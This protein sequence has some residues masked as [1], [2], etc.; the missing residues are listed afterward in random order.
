[1]TDVTEVFISTSPVITLFAV[2]Y[3]LRRLRFFD[4]G[5][6]DEL[7]KLVLYVALPALLFTVFRNLPLSGE[8]LTYFVIVFVA[9]GVLLGLG[10]FLTRFVGLRS[11]YAPFMFTGFETGMLGYAVFIAAFGADQASR[12][13]SFDLGQLF[14]VWI[15]LIGPLLRLKTGTRKPGEITVMFFR[16]PVVL[17]IL[18][19]LAANALGVLVS[20]SVKLLNTVESIAHT[21]SLITVPL[22]SIIIGYSFTVDRSTLKHSLLT[23][24][25]RVPL[26]LVLA[27][28]LERIVLFRVLSLDSMYRGAFMTMFLLP[29]PF[30]YT[31]FLRPHD[32]DNA[33]YLATT[34]SLHTLV[35]IVLF[36]FIVPM[37]M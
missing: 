27:F 14:F 11:A 30:V 3:L 31:L 28:F 8:L 6:V 17:G 18:T 5:F 7:R 34:Y 37:I 21:A 35:S 16:S 1:M 12:L 2:G 25:L 26:T 32:D 24:L 10:V 36:I 9:C 22:I 20:E 23:I 33:S 4:Q 15:V 13:A 19:G 29:P